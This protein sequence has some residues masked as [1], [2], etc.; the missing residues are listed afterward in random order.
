MR[1][2]FPALVALLLL[3]LPVVV[4]VGPAGATEHPV[5]TQR[6]TIRAAVTGAGV[7]VSDVDVTRR[8]R[9][10]VAHVRL[11][12][13]VRVAAVRLS[14]VDGPSDPHNG[15]SRAYPRLFD[16]QLATRT[17]GTARDGRW[18]LR[19]RVP[20]YAP[21]T[22]YHL[23]VRATLASGRDVFRA[24]EPLLHVT[25]AE[26]DVTPATL[27]RMARPGVD[28]QV[29][30]AGRLRVRVQTTDARSGVDQ[31]QVCWGP[32]S[33]EITGYCGDLSKIRGDRHDGV[34]GAAL[35]MR[36]MPLGPAEI[37][38]NVWD[39]GGLESSWLG[40]SHAGTPYTDLIPGGRGGFEVVE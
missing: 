17:A 40:P 8:S 12:G 26:P 39:R 11:T 1:S 15:G 20:R 10:V 30:R 28:Q 24:T 5:G 25:D 6:S 9:D 34:W 31:V 22:D 13:S 21:P 23:A 14:L 4:T 19:I 7:S 35:T 2:R 32:L 16:D 29:S 36:D 18:E 3:I 33:G 37:E 38:V 27:V